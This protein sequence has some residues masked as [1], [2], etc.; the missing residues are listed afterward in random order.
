[1]SNP[2]YQDS[3]SPSTGAQGASA[4]MRAEFAAIE[5]G[6][7]LLPTL[8]GNSLKIVGVNVGETALTAVA[9]SGTGSVVL[10]TSPTLTTP[11]IT[12]SIDT[13]SVS[14]TAFAGATTSLTIGG[15]GSAAVFAIPGTLQATGTTGALT[16]AGGAYIAKALNTAGLIT[17]A[18]G[19]TLSGTAANIALGSNFISTTG[20]DAGLSVDGS[21]NFTMSANLAVGGTLEVT[22]TTTLG[23]VQVNGVLTQSSSQSGSGLQLNVYNTANTASSSAILALRV[24]GTSAGN[25]IVQYYNG[26][27]LMYSGLD[28]SAGKYYI[29]PQADSGNAGL[30]VATGS[31]GAVTIPGTL[32][33]TGTL[34]VNGIISS[35]AYTM[36]MGNGGT[37][38]NAANLNIDAGSGSN[39]YGA[40]RVK[41]NSVDKVLFGVSGGANQLVTGDVA[42]DTA[43]QA[44]GNIFF[45]A[46]SGTTAHLKIATTGAVTIPGTLT[47]NGGLVTF[48]AADSGGAGKRLMLVPN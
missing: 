8:T 20:T 16:V 9:T 22:G 13:G 38:V 28:F 23:T 21:N 40:M 19:L 43:I 7:D 26:T 1:M 24:G 27:A 34:G 4:T 3:G 36:N 6:F 33:V 2:Y 46:D 41:R 42:N 12:T 48:G 17:S 35:T 10:A 5:A 29:G 45:S 47:T 31:A 25:S 18:G 30:T 15:T 44:V 14:F 39:S 32:G 37:G 11:V